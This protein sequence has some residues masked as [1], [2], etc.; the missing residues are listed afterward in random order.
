[1]TKPTTIFWSLCL[2]AATPLMANAQPAG[3]ALEQRIRSEVQEKILSKGVPSVSVAVMRDG[4]LLMAGAWGLADGDKKLEA[5]TSTIY[6]IGSV[7]KEFT[8]ALVLKL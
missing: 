3:A 5:S 6:P 4:K 8:A 7:S 2:V 1:M